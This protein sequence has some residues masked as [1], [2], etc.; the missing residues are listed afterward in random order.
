MLS[1]GARG[2]LLSS[3]LV[4]VYDAAQADCH[5]LACSRRSVTNKTLDRI[6]L[7]KYLGFSNLYLE[8]FVKYFRGNK[9]TAFG[10]GKS[11]V[12]G[13]SVC[14]LGTLVPKFVPIRPL[15]ACT[16]HHQSLHEVHYIYPT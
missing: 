11:G 14:E 10:P 1:T 15:W 3:W 7:G 13:F 2:T 6:S 12:T 4:S 16:I 5:E 9:K 8:D